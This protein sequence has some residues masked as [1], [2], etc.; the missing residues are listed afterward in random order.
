MSV[1]NL[2][3]YLFTGDR[4]AILALAADRRALWVGLVFV[5]SAGFAR[6]YDGQ[7]LLHEPWHLLIPVGASLG[8]ASLLFLVVGGR[9]CWTAPNWGAAFAAYRSFLTLFWLTA[10]LAWLYAVPYERFLSQGGA[11]RA[12]LLT[13]AVVA[14]WRVLLMTRV[15]SVLSGRGLVESA[16]LVLAFADGVVVTAAILMPKPLVDFMGGIRHT[17]SESVIVG[18]TYWVIFLGLLASP[19]LGLFGL[20]A[21]ATGK[22][23][24]EVLHGPAV[25]GRGMWVLAAASLLVWLPVLPWTQ[26]EQVLRWRAERAL[27]AGRIGEG[28][29]LMSAHPQSDFP[30]QWEPPPR[31]GYGENSPDLFEVTDAVLDRGS[32]PWVLECYTDKFR[33]YLGEQYSFYYQESKRGPRLAHLVRILQRLP[34]GPE[35]AARYADGVKQRL[36]DKQLPP[37]DR[38]NL[39]ALVKLAEQAK[40]AK[41]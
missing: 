38:D 1:R 29:D 40:K 28:L 19:V 11:T 27:K 26:G 20:Y 14:A 6:E 13:L 32:A 34:E 33:R 10:P 16:A 39:T 31:T 4:Q 17:E 36:D 22:P 2:L 5:L 12:N 18:V 25:G 35:L 41:P 3:L 8:A 15:T 23:T 21:L 9:Y 30:P 37:D 7:D 24:W